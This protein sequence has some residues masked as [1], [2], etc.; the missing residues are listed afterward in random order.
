M[1]QQKA[2]TE[3]NRPVYAL[4]PLIHNNQVVRRLE[5]MGVQTVES[6]QEAMGGIL[7]IRAHGVPRSII[8]EAEALGVEIADTTC[9]FVKRVHQKAQELR[10]EGYQLVIVGERDHPEVLGILGWVD[11]E[12]HVV[13]QPR[14]VL[15]LPALRRVGVVAQTTQTMENLAG[16]V[17]ELMARCRDL[18]ICNTLCDATVQRQSAAAELARGAAVMVVVGG[19]HSGNTR[20][21]AEICQATGTPTYHIETADDLDPAWFSDLGPDDVV[22]LTAGASTPDW[23]IAS[24]VEALDKV[25][26]PAA[27]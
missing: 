20:R 18:R 3:S 24:V 27:G 7:I 11:G 16:C 5:E 14:E 10:S 23:T 25:L 15:T 21:L 13:E 19:Y 2:Q 17:C 22:G 1:A 9:P 4:G 12:A 8:E 6:V 26:D